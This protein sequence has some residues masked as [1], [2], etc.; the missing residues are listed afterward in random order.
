MK[1]V[2]VLREAMEQASYKTYHMV[3][4]AMGAS[5]YWGFFAVLL[6]K[7]P[8]FA[9]QKYKFPGYLQSRKCKGNPLS[10]LV[11]RRMKTAFGQQGSSGSV[12]EINSSP[13]DKGDPMKA[14]HLLWLPSLSYYFV[15]LSLL[16]N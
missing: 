13:L 6:E 2:L 11:R 7:L 8:Y 10:L 3:S 1:R 4:T 5:Y 15:H 12:W 9:V 16:A 14:G